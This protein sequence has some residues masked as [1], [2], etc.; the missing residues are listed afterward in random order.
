MDERYDP[1]NLFIKGIKY[2]K[3]YEIY[4]E[5]NKSQPE[6]T[7]A[8]RIKAD[9]KDLPN[10]PPVECD[11]DVKLEL[12]KTSAE[13]VKLNPRKRKIEGKGFKYLTQIKAGNN[14]NK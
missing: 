1:R 9:D 12:D 13:R 3:W 14:S 11:E 5:E 4:K 6:E 7:L 10:M 2:D 8:E